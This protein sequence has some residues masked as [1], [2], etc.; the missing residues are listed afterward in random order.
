MERC[1]SDLRRLFENESKLAETL[2]YYKHIITFT[3]AIR[4]VLLGRDRRQIRLC[5][6]INPKR[7]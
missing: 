6:S 1:D 5:S 7:S 4:S 3:N 2:L